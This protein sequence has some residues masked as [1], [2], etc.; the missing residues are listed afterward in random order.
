MGGFIAL[1]VCQRVVPVVCTVKSWVA[2]PVSSQG[3]VY[4]F[5]HVL[6]MFSLGSPL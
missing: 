1:L 3:Q 4:T 2:C 6:N 5:I